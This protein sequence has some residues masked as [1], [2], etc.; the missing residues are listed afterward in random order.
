MGGS[1]SRVGVAGGAGVG[2][3]ASKGIKRVGVGVAV[4]GR[5]DRPGP[6][7]RKIH[8][9]PRIETTPTAIGIRRERSNEERGGIP[10][11]VLPRL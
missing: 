7:V 8:A 2:V 4:G 6:L 3:L 11:I 10:D 5:S 9:I 1:S